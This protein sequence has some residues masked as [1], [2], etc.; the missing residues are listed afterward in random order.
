MPTT[1]MEQVKGIAEEIFNTDVMI[2]EDGFVN[3]T[4][5][6]DGYS[7]VKLKALNKFDK[8]LRSIGVGY[9]VSTIF[10]E[11]DEVLSICIEKT[12]DKFFEGGWE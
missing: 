8:K 2:D 4:Q 9:R 3:I 6:S 11:K 1:I 7:S 12:T 5:D 10:W